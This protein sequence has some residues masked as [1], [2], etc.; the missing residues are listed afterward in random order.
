[1]A[2]GPDGIGVSPCLVFLLVFLD[3]IWAVCNIAVRF[4]A[5]RGC[6]WLGGVPNLDKI[7]APG[8]TPLR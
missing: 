2:A 7:G 1:M 8:R 6:R 5:A 3:P 4:V